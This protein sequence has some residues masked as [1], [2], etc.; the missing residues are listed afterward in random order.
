MYEQNLMNSC[1]IT[2][3]IP[4]FDAAANSHSG[5]SVF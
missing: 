2:V 4:F 5:K 3:L 1:S